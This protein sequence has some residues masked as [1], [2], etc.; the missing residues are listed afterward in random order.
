MPESDKVIELA[1]R[2]GI[3]WPSYEIYGGVAGLYD[4]GPVGARIKNKIINTWR[5]IFVEENSE[6]VVEIETPMIT[7]SKVLE[8]S[9]HVENFTDPIV[10]CTK[11]HKIYR[12][13]HLVEEMLKINVERLKPSELTSLISEKGLKCPSC[14]GDLGEVRSFNLLFATNIGPYSGTTGYLRP[15]TAQGMF[16]SFKRVYE[17]TRQ[18]LPLGIAQVGRVAR[19]EISPRQGLV[20]MREFTIMEVEFFIDPDDRNV[21]WLDRYYNEEFRVLFGDAKVKGLKPATM[22]V[23]EMIEEGLLV[24]PWMGFWMASA[25]R[26]VQALG[27]SKDRFYF[28]EKLPEERAHY[29]SQTFD[30]IVEI[31]GEK[32]EISGHAYRGNY[33]LSRHSKFS[34]EDL[35][36]FKKFDQPRTVVKKTVI[37]NRDRFKDN[38]E[39]QKEVM[40]LVSGK[41]PEQVEELLNKQVQVAGRPLSEF[42]RIMNREEKEHGIKFYPH[43]VEPSFGV[44]RCLYLSVLSAYREKKD[45]VVLALPKDLAPYQVAV[46]PLLERDELIKK[47]REIYNLLSGK[48]EVL[49]DDAGSIGKRYARVDEIGVPYAVTV[50]PQ[51]LSDDS[52]TIRDRDSWSQIRIKTSDLGSVMDKLFSGQDFSMLTGEAKR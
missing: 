27:I 12:A 26:F 50:D 37:V 21:P 5:K 8:A 10:E 1:K 33:D 47:A 52:V 43:V 48:Y 35:T 11:C 4:I 44:E 20:R 45:R 49:F 41:S 46:F 19:N 31:M 51:T 16:T 30:Q 9:G 28:E 23:K 25:S 36:V 17:A 15:E 42:V 6:F 39:L 22:K 24:N 14:G 13:D 18:R 7:P 32:V 2:R 38:P 40:M 29:S 34:N 3:F